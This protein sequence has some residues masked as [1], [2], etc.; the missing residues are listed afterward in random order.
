MNGFD[1]D[2]G[3]VLSIGE[4]DGEWHAPDGMP[5]V[6]RNGEII[7]RATLYCY[8][9][10]PLDDPRLWPQTARPFGSD[11]RRTL[12]ECALP[13][14]INWTRFRTECANL[15][16]EVQIASLL[17]HRAL[18]FNS[19]RRF[20]DSNHYIH[21]IKAA[22]LSGS[23]IRVVIPIF[24][25][26]ANPLKRFRHIS[27]TAGEMV[28]L[29]TLSNISGMIA[30]I[31][32]PGLVFEVVSDAMFYATPF[33]VHLADA[34]I[35]LQQLRRTARALGGDRVRLHDMSELLADH[36]PE[37]GKR[38]E[39]WLCRY[40]HNEL[41]D[42][43]S[44]SSLDVWLESMQACLNVSQYKHDYNWLRETFSSPANRL[45]ANP[46]RVRARAALLKYRA[47]KAAASDVGWEERVFPGAL[48]ATIHTK[49]IPVLGLRLYPEYKFRS[50]LLPYHGVPL[51][52]HSVKT[53]LRRMV[54]EPEMYL[55]CRSELTRVVD[56]TGGT[57][58]YDECS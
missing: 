19:R 12:E 6:A 54:I 58:F 26:I 34:A 22:C 47:L 49:S 52:Q 20:A 18:Q 53:G 17:N 27:I 24:C 14:R 1:A 13:A 5:D 48:R 42:G 25:V 31:Y 21:R 15:P 9:Q 29:R 10:L 33:G 44:Q 50:R 8:P 57:V 3:A 36:A 46:L 37:F 30:E 45:D 35:Y 2:P 7:N 56:N 41:C 11:D 4:R 55:A 51:I 23:P 38:Y 28:T 43:T 39:R 32:P 16:P 40:T